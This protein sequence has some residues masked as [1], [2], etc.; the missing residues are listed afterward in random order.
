[1]LKIG[2][3][4]FRRFTDP[5]PE[6]PKRDHRTL[7]AILIERYGSVANAAK[8]WNKARSHLAAMCRGE[9][10]IQPWVWEKLDE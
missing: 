2:D 5:L 6:R 8:A 4:Y 3:R 9:S 1:M 7:N 10:K